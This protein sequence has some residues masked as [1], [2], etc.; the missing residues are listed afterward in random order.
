MARLLANDG[1]SP[2]VVTAG[3]LHDV[4]EDTEVTEAEL[5][6]AF[7]ADIA[8]LVRALTQDTSI[9]KYRQRKTAL[10]AQILEAGP[11][12]AAISLADKAAK[13]QGLD[14]RPAERKL[15]HYRGTLR[16][17]EQRWGPSDLSELLRAQLSRWPGG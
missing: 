5:E 9:P 14:K 16:E 13:L 6:A 3:M 1:R 17:V 10:R 4:L 7:G 11:D 8:R 2:V 12:A 15:E